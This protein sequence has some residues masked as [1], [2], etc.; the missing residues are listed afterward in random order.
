MKRFIKIKDE[1]SEFFIATDAIATM[2]TDAGASGNTT[3]ILKE[4]AHN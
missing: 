3:I 4:R 1:D 2:A